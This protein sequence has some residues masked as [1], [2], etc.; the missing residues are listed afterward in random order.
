VDV[1]LMQLAARGLTLADLR[2]ALGDAAFDA[3]AGALSSERQ[4][5][6]VRTTAAIRTP[7]RSRR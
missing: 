4:S 3:P 1:D 2:A 7:R 6:M 5:L